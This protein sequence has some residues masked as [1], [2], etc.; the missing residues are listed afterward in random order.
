[1]RRVIDRAGVSAGWRS[2]WRWWRVAAQDRP[3]GASEKMYRVGGGQRDG[4]SVFPRVAYAQM[5]PLSEGEVDFQHFHTLR[6]SD[7]AAAEVGGGVSES[8]RAVLG[9]AV[10]RGARDLA[11]HDHQQEDR[12]RTPTSRVLHRRRAARRRDHRHRGDA[13][14]RQPRPHELRQGRR[15]HEAGRHEGDLR[16]AA[17]QSRRRVALPLHGADA[18]LDGAARRQR[19][20]RPVRRGRR[21]GPRRRRLR[22]ADAQVR[23]RRQGQG[24]RRRARSARAG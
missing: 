3:G 23:R 15:D 17:Q 21:R 18:A 22:P 8:R 10:A 14:L 16:E 13:L 7:D 6:G 4:T 24:H 11:D 19:R 9:R 20:R 12:Q 5:K 1:M 2:V